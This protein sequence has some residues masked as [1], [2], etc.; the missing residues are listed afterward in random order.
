[1]IS[2]TAPGK[3]VLS[4]E[5][6]VLNDAPAISAAV[7]R[8]VH[9]SVS[10][11]PGPL[12][13]VNAPGYLQG[14]WNFQAGK[15]GDVEWQQELPDPSSFA[16]VEEVWKCFDSSRWPALKLVIDTREFRDARTGL[17][18]G[19]GSSAAVAVALTAALQKFALLDG[20][21]GGLAMHSHDRFQGGRGSGVDVATS[22]T[23]GLIVYRRAGA[24]IRRIDWPDG[25]HY[26]YLWSGQ[27]AST[28]DRLAR[29]RCAGVRDDEDDG[30]D[31]LAELAMDV[32]IAWSRGDT[33]QVLE[34]YPGY[35]E[36]LNQFSADHELG[37]FDAGH[38]EL[39]RVAMES[40]IVYKP[41]GAGGGDIGI[42]LAACEHDIDEFCDRLVESDFRALDISLEEQGLEFAE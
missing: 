2:T 25:L 14:S 11:T 21:D 8:R 15:D 24:E 41:C 42:V 13:C 7:D 39:A 35:I 10:E 31:L 28:A 38:E 30:T 32:A 36:A 16:L 4:G 33:N 18:L 23:G 26:R 29:L 1:M 40:G 27:A 37:I 12:H 3:A 34:S 17:K 5:Y 6:A 20:D 19:L 9:V 22:F